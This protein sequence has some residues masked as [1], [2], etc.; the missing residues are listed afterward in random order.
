MRFYRLV[1]LQKIQHIFY[2][3]H[4]DIG[5]H[6]AHMTIY[7]E[8][9]TFQQLFDRRGF[10]WSALPPPPDGPFRL[11]LFV[12]QHVHIDELKGAHFVVQQTHP[13]SHGRLADDVDHVATLEKDKTTNMLT[14]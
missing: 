9:D 14:F 13:C 10:G 2:S 12:A 8:V 6:L 7:L 1:A 3:T 5:Q 11:L 4:D